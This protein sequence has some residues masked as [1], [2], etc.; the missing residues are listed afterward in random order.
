MTFLVNPMIWLGNIF[1]VLFIAFCVLLCPTNSNA[2][3]PSCPRDRPATTSTFT[4]LGDLNIGFIQPIYYN[5]DGQCGPRLSLGF[6]YL[7]QIIRA[8]VEEINADPSILPGTKLGFVFFN[9]CQNPPQ[10]LRFAVKGI[11]AAW[12]PLTH[13]NDSRVPI[14][15]IIGC[16]RSE[17]SITMSTYL[18]IFQI[19]LISTSSTAQELSNKNYH[20]FF[21]RL[22][23]NS[24]QMGLA[25]ARLAE[26]F[27]WSYL[28]LIY[29]SMASTLD[30]VRGLEE[31]TNESSQIFCFSTRSALLS[32]A[33]EHTVRKIVR[34]TLKSLG[35]GR[36]VILLTSYQMTKKIL[37]EFKHQ[38][39]NSSRR[40]IFIF[41]DSFK[42]VATE[43]YG[44]L[45]E[46]SF[47]FDL[48]PFKSKFAAKI[49]DSSYDRMSS[50]NPWADAYLVRKFKCSWCSRN[51]K[52]NCNNFRKTPMRLAPNVGGRKYF[53]HFRDF[54]VEAAT[55]AFAR[56]ADQEVRTNCRGF[57]DFAKCLTGQAL[58]RRLLDLNFS[59]LDANASQIPIFFDQNGD[60]LSGRLFLRQVQGRGAN[61]IL[62]H[63]GTFEVHN[64]SLSLDSSQLAWP[65][66]ISD[67]PR[68]VCS[69]PCGHGSAMVRI[70][71]CCWTCHRCAVNQI[72]TPSNQTDREFCQQC[73][74]LWWPNETTRRT[75]SPIATSPT[76][77]GL[78]FGS[79][80][81]ATAGIL[82]CV[83]LFI[84]M[85]LYRNDKLIRATSLPISLF[86]LACIMAI[87]L[88]TFI[89]TAQASNGLCMALELLFPFIYTT[90][91]A[92]LLVRT[93]RIFLIFRASDRLS[94]RPRLVDNRSQVALV[95]GII[96]GQ[97]CLL[98]GL[99]LSHGMGHMAREMPNPLQ[100]VIRS[101]CR[102]TDLCMHL[103]TF[104]N[105]VL[106]FLSAC[107]GFVT[108]HLPDNFRE[109]MC[110]FLC[111]C[112]T[113]LLWACFLPVYSTI[114]SP[115]SRKLLQ[116][117][118]LHL[119][120]HVYLA[121]LFLPKVFAIYGRKNTIQRR[122]VIGSKKTDKSDI[123]P[124]RGNLLH[125]MGR[126]S[127]SADTERSLR[128]SNRSQLK[129]GV[130][131]EEERLMAAECHSEVV[132]SHNPQNSTDS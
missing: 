112:S 124:Q 69:E 58:H 117:L 56:A 61:F 65:S 46:G 10:S 75:C 105:A 8:T 54:F 39:G 38:L 16:Q 125:Q 24:R 53:R 66:P 88:E 123:T 108:R 68:S 5:K 114:T 3:L 99:T 107:L 28:S 100:P 91:Y 76:P 71:Q 63:V 14:I 1:G 32:S 132:I 50:A 64:A 73:P 96:T 23:S 36:V 67:T 43:Q 2:K 130:I 127:L 95:A 72:V 110:L 129:K 85:V 55:Q 74:E 27:G 122:D 102:S 57:K 11:R 82:I 47:Y 120:A 60:L 78:Q 83:L 118:I 115:L 30:I 19:P 31:G 49:A 42:P 97:A 22:V 25:M 15:G 126:F 37:L 18:Q 79:A 119:S 90:L 131:K 93:L 101:Y 4:Q 70:D 26:Y 103:T 128:G 40:L 113:L 116:V 20:P 86:V 104:Y 84:F 111:A 52:R 89:H 6:F 35:E 109:T 45:L 33:S 87:F 98:G 51:P 77:F 94:R 13:K 80:V 121:S 34:R 59:L 48:F 21:L 17:C 29:Q 7:T 81:C 12:D 62:Q 92:A 41:V 44:G 106:I 9:N